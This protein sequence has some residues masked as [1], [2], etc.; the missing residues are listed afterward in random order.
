MI[1]LPYANGLSVLTGIDA[2]LVNIPG[3]IVCAN[4]G[5]Q[6]ISVSQHFGLDSA[7]AQKAPHIIAIAEV[8]MLPSYLL[9]GLHVM[10]C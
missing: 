2:R 7:I 3:D 9:Q 1:Q 10:Q 8:I 5:C 4:I 6:S